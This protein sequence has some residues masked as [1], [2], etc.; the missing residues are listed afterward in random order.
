MTGVYVCDVPVPWP[1]DCGCH[2]CIAIH[3]HC[4]HETY[5]ARHATTP[6]ACSSE[7]CCW[8]FRVVRGP[9]WPLACVACTVQCVMRACSACTRQRCCGRLRTALAAC[10]RAGW[11]DAS[12]G[13]AWVAWVVDGSQTRDSMLAGMQSEPGSRGATLGTPTPAPH[14]DDL[15]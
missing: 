14:H 12:C 2:Y 8:C 4:T 7:A 6:L 15:R 11:N 10:G 13:R 3:L 9:W 5:S 1:E